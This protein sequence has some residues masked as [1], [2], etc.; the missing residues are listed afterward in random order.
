M[1]LGGFSLS[2]FLQPHEFTGFFIVILIIC[3]A[4][5]LGNGS[6]FKIIPFVLPKEAGAAI[7]IVS[8]LGALGGFVPPLLLG[9]T[10]DHPARSKAVIAMSPNDASNW[11]AAGGR[12]PTPT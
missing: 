5:G 6:V 10:M 12:K 8:C 1:A 9:W 2:A 11:P 7:G 4:A 3:A